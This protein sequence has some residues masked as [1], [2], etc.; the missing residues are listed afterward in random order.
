M[1]RVLTA[2]VLARCRS[3]V[4]LTQEP[5]IKE[6]DGESRGLMGQA[7]Q[8]PL[9]EQEVST[10][11]G[12]AVSPAQLY[13]HTYTLHHNT[14]TTTYLYLR[15]VKGATETSINNIQPQ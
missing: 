7:L 1:C 6:P 3:D 8:R 15:M 4:H 5:I 14:H 13:T 12:A 2:V 11:A 10:A 9:G